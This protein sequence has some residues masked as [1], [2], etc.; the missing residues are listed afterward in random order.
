M[1]QPDYFTQAAIDEASSRSR[2]K[3]RGL[4][5]RIAALEAQVRNLTEQVASLANEEPQ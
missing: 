4:E 3:A 5:D 2:I 1:M